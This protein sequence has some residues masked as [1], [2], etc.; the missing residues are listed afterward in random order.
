MFIY[1]SASPN[2]V[3]LAGLAA[4]RAAAEDQMRLSWS[5]G[6]M[7]KETTVTDILCANSSPPLKYAEFT[8][9]EEN[10]VGADWVWWWID[11]STGE[12]F[13]MLVQAKR[14]ECSRGNRW[15]VNFGYQPRSGEGDQVT[16]LLLAARHL[17]ISAGYLVYSGDKLYRRNLECGLTCGGE[18]DCARCEQISVA[19]TSGLMA[20]EIAFEQDFNG[21]IND[22]GWAMPLDAL[23]DPRT[24]AQ[25]FFDINDE[26]IGTELRDFLRKPQSDARHVARAIFEQVSNKRKQQFAALD[27]KIS[28]V[29]GGPIF[30]D[31]PV[32]RGH[33]REPYWPFVLRGLRKKAP[34]YV[35]DIAAGSRPP[36]WLT[37]YA[38]GLVVVEM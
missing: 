23:A 28:T 4:G 24:I 5:Q 35:H 27:S 15:S 34:Q 10:A 11:S 32:D 8:Q 21:T 26:C 38:R 17:N 31:L 30:R 1:K 33:L 2:P 9:F 25:P 14:L 13:G 22:L 19:F 7:W 36:K 18:L 37:R 29:D 16:R 20:A 6:H 3:V 12:A